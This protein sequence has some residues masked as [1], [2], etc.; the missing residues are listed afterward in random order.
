MSRTWCPL[1][2][3]SGVSHKSAVNDQD[4][5]EKSNKWPWLMLW[6]RYDYQILTDGG[7]RQTRHCQVTK[8]SETDNAYASQFRNQRL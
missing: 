1:I 6:Q 4:A 3:Y 7:F 5:T 2:V 8:P